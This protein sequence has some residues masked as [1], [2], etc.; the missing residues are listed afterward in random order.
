MH[1]HKKIILHPHYERYISKLLIVFFHIKQYMKKKLIRTSISAHVGTA[2][3][4]V[5]FKKRDVGTE[6]KR[7]RGTQRP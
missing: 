5:E 6:D 1:K 3:S 4:N 2:N 7:R